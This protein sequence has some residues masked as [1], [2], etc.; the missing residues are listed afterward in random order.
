MDQKTVW[1]RHPRPNT[2]ARRARAGACV[3][4]QVMHIAEEKNG[5]RQSKI[6]EHLLT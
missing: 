1:M 2:R 3:L 4:P 6:N 5:N